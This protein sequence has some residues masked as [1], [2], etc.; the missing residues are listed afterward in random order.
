[1]TQ[2]QV[3]EPMGKTRAYVSAIERGVDWDPEAPSLR[4]WAETLGWERDYILMRLGRTGGESVEYP[5]RL[6]P[7]L[8][9]AIRD[10]VA[11]GVRQAIAEVLGPGRAEGPQRPDSSPT[12]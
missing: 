2:A 3:A 12:Q 1:M 8:K 9:A 4:I 7:A 6:T 10:A 5:A 11:E